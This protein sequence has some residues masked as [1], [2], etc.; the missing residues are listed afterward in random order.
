MTTRIECVCCGEMV[1]ATELD[2]D[3]ICWPCNEEDL[4]DACGEHEFDCRC[5][6]DEEGNFVYGFEDDDFGDDDDPWSEED[7]WEGD[8]YLDDLVDEDDDDLW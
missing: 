8:D 6:D 4:C 1:D 7:D 5:D 3:G 2:S